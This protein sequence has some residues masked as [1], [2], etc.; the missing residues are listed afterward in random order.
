MR[1]LRSYIIVVSL[2]LPVFVLHAQQK[3]VP[4]PSPP[5]AAIQATVDKEKIVIG[6]PIHLR[7][8]V[9]VPDNIPFAWPG[10]DSLPHFDWLDKGKIDTTVR[11]GERSYRQYL[12]LTSFDSGTWAIPRLPFLAGSK[13]VLSDSIR[14][15][16]GYTKIDPSKDFHDIK[17]I[18]D[19][20]NPFARWIG[21]IV[22]A[23]TLA[24]AALVF[25]LIWKKKLLKKLESAA[26]APRLSPYEE[27]IKQLEELERQHLP[28]TGAMKAYYSRMSEILRVYLLRRLQIASL[29]ETSEELIGQLRRQ[30]LPGDVFGGLAEALRMSDFVKF[31]KYQPGIADSGQH[32][33][34]VRLAIETLEQHRKDEEERKASAAAAGTR[35]TQQIN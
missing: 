9:T 32:F 28:D 18:I 31:A 7:L 5:P 17:D 4:K 15:S 27:A 13:T 23:F 14:I 2:F 26:A 11:P 25:W 21:W 1:P 8:D 30:A 24:C 10:L 12:T 19:V 6:E 3:H 22:A 35:E 20:P 33:R 29:T 34:G 16:V